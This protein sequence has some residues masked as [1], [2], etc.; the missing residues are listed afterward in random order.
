MTTMRKPTWHYKVAT[1]GRFYPKTQAS[2]WVFD[3]YTYRM[4]KLTFYGGAGTVTGSNFLIEGKKGR[5]LVD[6]GLE[7][8]KDVN[9]AAT[10]APFPYD[11]P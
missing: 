3:C 2:A 8:G 11:V 10:Y 7:Q 6:C 9:D 4:L 1:R 5:L